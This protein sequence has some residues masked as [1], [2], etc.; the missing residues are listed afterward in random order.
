M[1][2]QTFTDWEVLI[3]DD[4]STPP[5]DLTLPQA[6]VLRHDQSA[7][8]AAAKNTGIRVA[9]GELIAF[10]DDDDLYAHEYLA[11][12]VDVLDR[13]PSL[14]LVFMGVSWFGITR[15]DSRRNYDEAMAKTLADAK[16][17]AMEDGVLAFGEE[18]VDA[19]L[20]SVPMAFQR[21][22]V[23]RSA[24]E[25]IGGYRATC[26]LWDC[27]WAIRAALSAK[28]ALVLDGLYQQRADGQGYSSKGDRKLEQLQSNVEIKDQ[29]SQGSK[30]RN[31]A[32]HRAA[33]FRTAAAQAWFDLAWYHYQQGNGLAAAVA[34]WQS[35][36]RQF[37]LSRLKLVVR[38]LMPT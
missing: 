32:I 25:R 6:R 15:D 24:L 3:V 33:R 18:L 4:A 22:V 11:R 8:G 16:G 7:G 27:D 2:A 20:K 38:L 29:L 26:L 1:N 37:S 23:R 21:P 17:W 19:L 34:L 9:A 31:D 12:A 13:N 35:E 10:L 28:A 36:R 14:D 30:F 5:V